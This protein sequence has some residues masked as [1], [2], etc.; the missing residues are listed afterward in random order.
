MS[1]SADDILNSL[2]GNITKQLPQKQS[3]VKSHEVDSQTLTFMFGSEEHT[4]PYTQIRYVRRNKERIL[5][6]TYSAN[7]EVRGKNLEL[8][9]AQLRRY[10]LP[11]V[12]E[13]IDEEEDQLF[14]DSIS[15]TYTSEEDAHA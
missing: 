4:F 15:V 8:L 12:S 2:K 6:A 7:I 9:S 11:I 13:S 1:K 14:I 3:Q 10:K 5:I